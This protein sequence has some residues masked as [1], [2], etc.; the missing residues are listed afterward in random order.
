VPARWSGYLEQA[1]GAGGATAN[2]HY[3]EL[4]VLLALR[5]GLRCG[6]VFVPG[7]RRYADPAAYLLTAEAWARQRPEF[8]HLVGKPADA[9][10]ALAQAD[11]EPHTAL[12]DLQRVLADG[13]GPVRL[14]DAGDLV[15]PQ[16]SAEDIPAEAAALKA[17]LADLLPYAPVASLLV[18]LDRRTGFLDCFTHAGGNRPARRS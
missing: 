2:R 4:C 14:T 6:D 13:S 5:D 7:S 16:L 9:A 10:A 3:W 11:D 15:I 1:S 8:C 18:E 17:E 12:S